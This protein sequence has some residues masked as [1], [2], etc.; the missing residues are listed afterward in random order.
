MDIA[1]ICRERRMRKRIL[2]IR[3]KIARKRR[4]K[5]VVR[6][7]PRYDEVFSS[8]VAELFGELASN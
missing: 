1:S 8:G 4:E 6:P 3:A 2:E 5:K 7:I